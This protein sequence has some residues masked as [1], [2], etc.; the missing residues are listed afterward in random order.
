[1]ANTTRVIMVQPG[2]RI[3]ILSMRAYGNPFKYRAL[4]GTNPGLDI[5]NPEAG[6]MIEVP[7]A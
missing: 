4:L 6:T 1:M 5:W 2:D 7:D 3:D